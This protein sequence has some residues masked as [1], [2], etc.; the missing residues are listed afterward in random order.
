M[1]CNKDIMQL[2]YEAL[3]ERLNPKLA[4]LVNYI[5]R[6]QGK[7]LRRLDYSA[8]AEELGF[9]GRS[10]WSAIKRL[11]DQLAD[12]QIIIFNG[13]ML[14]LSDDVLKAG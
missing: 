11:C 3:N 1:R 2:D 8:A 13:N 10:G 9:T 4:E 14:R 6:C 7:E 5:F 12:K